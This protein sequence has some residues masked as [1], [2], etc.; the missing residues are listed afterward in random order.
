MVL[1]VSYV[2]SCRC[3]TALMLL[4]LI[5][6]SSAAYL[7][8]SNAKIVSGEG[9]D[10]AAK[11]EWNA[12]VM[13]E[14]LN[15]DSELSLASS[16]AALATA[17]QLLEQFKDKKDSEEKVLAN[18]KKHSVLGAT[19]RKTDSDSGTARKKTHAFSSS[20]AGDTQTKADTVSSS[21][22]GDMRTKANSSSSTHSGGTHATEFVRLPLWGNRREGRQGENELR[23]FGLI[24]TSSTIAQPTS[25]FTRAADGEAFGKRTKIDKVVSAG[26]IIGGLALIGIVFFVATDDSMRD[27]GSPRSSSSH[28]VRGSPRPTPRNSTKK[29]ATNGATSAAYTAQPATPRNRNETAKNMRSDRG[30]AVSPPSTMNL[31]PMERGPLPEV[32]S[33]D[34][35]SGPAPRVQ[36]YAAPK[37]PP[38]YTAPPPKSP[39]GTPPG[40]NKSLG[41]AGCMLGSSCRYHATGLH[42][43]TNLNPMASMF[44]PGLV[45]PESHECSL[46]VPAYGQG[47][48][49]ISDETGDAV[50]R[51]ITQMAKARERSPPGSLPGESDLPEFGGMASEPSAARD[52]DQ[53]F[54]SFVLTAASGTVLAQCCTASSPTS[55]P[56]VHLLSS[57]GEYHAKVVSGE[58]QGTYVLDTLNGSRLH[59]W[60]WFEDFAM[61]VT[62][63]EG[64]LLATTEPWTGNLSSQALDMTSEAGANM[65]YKLHVNPLTDVGLVLCGLLGL[66]YLVKDDGSSGY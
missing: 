58:S 49:D 15:Q 61:N 17:Q 25:R 22:S 46:I 2:V 4:C 31:T 35:E 33:R 16:A 37:S 9:E 20:D 14:H 38:T 47:S 34:I 54:R 28:P 18:A 44:C 42:S 45:V 63:D 7:S 24:Q 3:G 48:Y 21:D 59:F 11:A 41:N 39:S 62:D 57:A 32:A 40:S 29:H 50:L 13:D 12:F 65:R 8:R 51:V 19:H 64:T 10:T 30:L 23:G 55:V 56:E 5:A 60:G 36:T 66:E 26:L 6:P 27:S 1:P 43:Q 53:L 52:G